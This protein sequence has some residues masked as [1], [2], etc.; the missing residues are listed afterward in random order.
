MG[1]PYYKVKYP[2]HNL[3][4]TKTQVKLLDYI[5]K[6]GDKLESFIQSV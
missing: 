2:E 3:V 5:L 1:N 4:R 6:N